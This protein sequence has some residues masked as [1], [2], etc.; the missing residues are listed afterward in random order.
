[1]RIYLRLFGI[2]FS[3]VIVNTVLA[4]RWE[5]PD[6]KKRTTPAPV[7]TEAKD[8]VK[9]ISDKK[10]T[11]IKETKEIEVIKPEPM[12]KP[13]NRVKRD[14]ST[15][16]YLINPRLGVRSFNPSSYSG[17]MEINL[18]YAGQYLGRGVAEANFTPVNSASMLGIEMTV[19]QLFVRQKLILDVLNMGFFFN[20]AMSNLE[21]GSGIGWNFQ[22]KDI[23]FAIRP[24]LDI[25]YN[26]LTQT[27]S[28]FHLSSAVAASAR[29]NSS[30]S[31][32]NHSLVL[33]P[34]LQLAHTL[35]K[36]VEIRFN[37]AY[38]YNAA[39][40]ENVT[41]HYNRSTGR[42][43]TTTTNEGT[44]STTSG[45]ITDDKDQP[46]SKPIYDIGDNIGFSVEIGISLF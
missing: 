22:H 30:L 20:T 2:V 46:I 42:R 28:N 39:T 8:T 21:I 7:V 31:I 19:C 6:V 32:N 34:R 10:E 23:P 24:M 26:L 15:I 40:S 3:F 9:I 45:V 17:Q 38:R 33:Q 14:N 5:N 1:M 43:N 27:I 11:V 25:Q 44:A 36:T 12:S 13:D 4:Q 37:I 29:W 16:V 18:P 35:H 41:L